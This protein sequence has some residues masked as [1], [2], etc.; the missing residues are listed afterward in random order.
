MAYCSGE[1][2]DTDRASHDG[3]QCKQMYNKYQHY[4]SAR[5]NAIK[6]IP[7][8][9]EG[10]KD[11]PFGNIKLTFSYMFEGDMEELGLIVPDEDIRIL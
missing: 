1:H 6:S 9:L 5:L 8:Q 10:L 7:G 2:R 4:L 3:A 11:T